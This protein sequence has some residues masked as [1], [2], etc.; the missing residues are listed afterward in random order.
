MMS[1]RCPISRVIAPCS[2]TTPGHRAI[3]GVDA[4]L[5]RP[6]LVEAKWRIADVGPVRT[7][8]Q[9]AAWLAGQHAPGISA[10]DPVLRASSVVG[11]EQHQRIV[12]HAYRLQFAQQPAD[13]L[14]H[15]VDLGGVGGHFHVPHLGAVVLD[16]PPLLHFLPARIKQ[17]IFGKRPPLVDQA[18]LNLPLV[19]APAPAV[20]VFHVLAP[21]LFDIFR[22]CLKGK[23]RGVVRHVGKKWRFVFARF[24]HEPE[25]V[26]R[27]GIRRVPVR[28]LRLHFLAVEV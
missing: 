8:G 27:V 14:V 6:A 12:G 4:A 26:V 15:A 5:M 13:V 10:V 11:H 19:A 7:I 3:S 28:A 17:R 20:P 24:L 23:V 21:V 1:T 9:R 25:H 2:L 18:H 22:H 16:A